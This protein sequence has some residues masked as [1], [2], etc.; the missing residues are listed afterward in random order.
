[1]LSKRLMY[2]LR[3][4][5]FI[6]ILLCLRILYLNVVEGEYY[7]NI[8]KSSIYK[9][10]VIPAP[11]GEI[12]DKNGI[13]LAGS[14][15]VFTV[16]ISKNDNITK[17]EFNDVAL[18]LSKILV[19]NN[20]NIE[21]SFPI[22]LENGNFTYSFDEQ[23]AKWKTENGI[24][25]DAN[26][27]TAFYQVA[28]NFI[29]TNPS[30]G[31]T[32]DS[33]PIVLQ[34]TLNDCG[35][36]P[37][38]SIKD[39]FEFTKT[40]EKNAWLYKYG[41]KDKNTS[42]KDAFAK[43]RKSRNIKEELS[44]V[45][46]RYILSMNDAIVSKAYLQYEPAVIAK[47][48]S[49]KTVSS[50]MERKVELKNVTVQAEPLRYYPQ[51][52][53][54]AHIIGQI[55]KISSSDE[56][57][58]KDE[59]YSKQDYVGKSGIELYYES[60]LKGV[61]GYEKVLVDSV[62]KKI[63][64]I[65]SKESYPGNSVYLSIDAKLQKVAED[66]LKKTLEK[67]QTGGVYDSTWGNVKMRGANRIYNHA[68][69]GAIVALDAKT[70]K[71]LA[72]ASYPAYD[73]N[74]FTDYMTIDEYNSLQPENPNDPLSAKPLLN[75]AT[76]TAVQPGSTFKMIS[77]L[78]ALENGLSPNYI[79]QDKGVI[80]I[81]GVQFKNWLYGENRGLQGPE[82]VI[83]AI[84]DS[85]NYF[86]FCISV[87]YNY[88]NDEPIPMGDM[89]NG[90]KIIDM[91]KKF[92]LNEKTGIEI[93]ETAGSVP[94]PDEKYRQQIARMKKDISSKMLEAYK[95]IT[96][97]N[98]EQEYNKRLEE[99]T[100][101][102]DENPSRA[103][104]IKRLSKLNVK[105]ELLEEIADLLKYTYFN[106]AQWST[107]DI[108][109]MSI[110]QGTHRYTPIQIAR[111]I[112]AVANGGYLNKVSVID[113]VENKKTGE[114]TKVEQQS[115]KVELNNPQN[116]DYV[117]QGMLLVTQQGTIKN[118]FSNFPVKIASKTGTAETQG[119]IPTKDEVGYYMSHLRDYGVNKKDVINL[120]NKLAAE[121]NNAY[122]KQYFIQMAILELNPKMTIDKLNRFKEPYADFSWFV[123]Y[124][125]YDDPQIVVVTFL[126]Q[127]GSST[128]ATPA[129][130]DVIAQYMGIYD[131]PV[132]LND[133]K[134]SIKIKS[135]QES[136][137][138]NVLK[139]E[140]LPIE[141]IYSQS[142]QQV[143]R[144]IPTTPVRQNKPIAPEIP[145][146][147]PD[148]PA[149]IVPTEV[150]VEN[151]PAPE[152]PAPAP[153]TPLEETPSAPEPVTAPEPAPTPDTNTSESPIF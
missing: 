99:I 11:R 27:K 43:L 132:I 10:I 100:S 130:R 56:D 133:E 111:Y 28:Q 138:T 40:A 19:K 65:D 29:D 87:A 17:E 75:V 84:K 146:Q 2:I 39:G 21:D 104:I 103:E 125:P 93:F 64:N 127:G 12:R 42:A 3:F 121:Y 148:L 49:Q 79:I 51:G 78:A 150:P 153:E 26:A 122:S 152:Q 76:M 46:A 131:K 38:I 22:K 67:L 137:N 144:N 15:P 53:L 52:T 9:N 142:S 91:A 140:E 120:S 37:P 32:K 89:K 48:I 18:I 70:G 119:K 81:A 105:N 35:I 118:I 8:E 20:E 115:Q 82:N 149:E 4:I 147:E 45:D 123:A 23:V 101:W 94:D 61:S 50:I 110:G 31:L 7:E 16:S 96:I 106:N 36:Y 124:A 112:A 44:D 77:A 136:N 126:T 88:A 85:N 5:I 108:F 58:L 59:R 34:K 141:N 24:A 72:M 80:S 128:F 102:A 41:I 14:K 57:L 98:N 143:N 63:S 151:S 30:Y 107:G 62:G 139:Q 69:S 25:L 117:K 92:G 145:V 109:N 13:L 71:V 6:C 113:K 54:A 90:M 135:E 60:Q 66:S 68:T 129:T 55:G 33:D 1:M 95:D 97:E 114:I 73:P 134:E 116:F 86:F 83:T 47:D 74:I